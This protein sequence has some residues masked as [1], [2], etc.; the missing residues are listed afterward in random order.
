MIGAV[1]GAAG[2]FIGGIVGAFGKKKALLDRAAALDRQADQVVVH[3][4]ETGRRNLRN[5]VTARGRASAG[6]GNI[7]AQI[8]SSGVTGS[9][10]TSMA[11][12]DEARNTQADNILEMYRE[13]NFAARE[14]IKHEKSIR[15]SAARMREAA[16]T[17][18][19][20]DM[21]GAATGGILASEQIATRYS[22]AGSPMLGKTKTP[23]SWGMEY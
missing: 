3:R 2:S 14:S 22:K 1:V 4:N 20:S 5:I 6:L 7:K 18:F 8:A 16:K 19:F 12:Q 15:A 21:F 11:I 23:F 9:S 17:S 10:S 13:H